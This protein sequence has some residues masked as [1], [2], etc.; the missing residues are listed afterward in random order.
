MG[1][2]ENRVHVDTSQNLTRHHHLRQPGL[3]G[4]IFLPGPPTIVE[5]AL[6]R[7]QNRHPTYQGTLTR[8]A[9]GWTA[10]NAHGTPIGAHTNFA[11]AELLILRLKTAIRARADYRWPAA[12]VAEL[13]DEQPTF[14]GARFHHTNHN[15]D[16]LWG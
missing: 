3:V 5:I 2:R 12:M 13:R 6:W 1:R 4:R 7:R 8:T 10:A 14:T 15:I 16:T 11:V 9:T